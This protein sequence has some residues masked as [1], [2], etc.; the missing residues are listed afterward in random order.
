MTGAGVEALPP[1]DEAPVEEAAEEAAENAA[2]LEAADASP[3]PRTSVAV[4][5]ASE[6]SEISEAEPVEPEELKVSSGVSFIPDTLS[7]AVAEPVSDE[8]EPVE[9]AAPVEETSFIETPAPQSGA[10]L[11]DLALAA[12]DVPQPEL[13]SSPFASADS[14][15]ST[16]AALG[17]GHDDYADDED[18]ASSANTDIF[19]KEQIAKPAEGAYVDPYSPDANIDKDDDDVGTIVDGPNPFTKSATEDG[20]DEY[21]D[22]PEL[23]ERHDDAILSTSVLPSREDNPRPRRDTAQGDGTELVDKQ[24]RDT[25]IVPKRTTGARV[26]GARTDELRAITN[27]PHFPTSAMGQYV[28]DLGRY[29]ANGTAARKF[30]MLLIAAVPAALVAWLIIALTRPTPVETRW[31]SSPTSMWTG[32]AAQRGYAQVD[33]LVRGEQLVAI[34]EPIESY[35]LVRDVWGRV[36]YV[37]RESLT[38]SRAGI[39]PDST[40]PGCRTGPTEND[41]AICDERARS[42]NENCRDTCGDEACKQRCQDRFV[43]CIAGCRAR[44]VV[45]APEPAP[46]ATPVA[47]VPP[48]TETTTEPIDMSAKPDKAKP[49]VKKPTKKE[50]VAKKPTPKTQ[51]APTKKKK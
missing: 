7:T 26:K 50:P 37:H 5:E 18:E 45:T 38:D 23:T 29:F 41:N 36:G 21:D 3:E 12:H 24:R 51:P 39:T 8:A 44:L 4:E 16:L 28:R 27:R 34:G 31:V 33:T 30:V 42:L 2:P 47:A 46:A 48:P 10:S 9:E 40:F 20:S 22:S 6:V 35:V 1:E 32:P 19:D 25:G 14:D 43:E 11:A 17:P 49:P 13:T 15:S